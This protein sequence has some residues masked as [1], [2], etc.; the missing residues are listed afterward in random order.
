MALM[1]E[2]ELVTSLRSWRWAACPLEFCRHIIDEGQRYVLNSLT[3]SVTSLLQNKSKSVKMPGVLGNTSVV[4]S[5]LV[6][7]TLRQPYFE[8]DADMPPMITI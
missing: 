2:K 6:A 3:L 5:F 7:L 8:V 4:T 1:R